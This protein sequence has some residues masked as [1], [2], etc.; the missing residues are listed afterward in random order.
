DSDIT[1]RSCDGLLFHIHRVNLDT[2]AGA[3]PPAELA[4]HAAEAV[5]LTEDGQTLELLFQFIY[6]WRQPTLEGVP[7]ERLDALAEAA[8][9]YEVFSAMGICRIRM[10]ETL[11]DHP[12]EIM[13]YAARH[14]Y[15]EILDAAAPLTISLPVSE[16]LKSLSGL[17]VVPYV[18]STI[19]F[20]PRA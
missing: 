5:D 14:S 3:F 15:F 7:F 2:H 4:C 19:D 12:V 10:R 8:E 17:F 20:L 9:K 6:P 1:F 11:P 13:N 16:V 18:R